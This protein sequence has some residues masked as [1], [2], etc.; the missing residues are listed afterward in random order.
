MIKSLKQRSI[1]CGPPPSYPPPIPP[2]NLSLDEKIIKKSSNLHSS[3]ISNPPSISPY[4][5]M[6]VKNTLL[7]KNIILPSNFG[8]PP[9][10]S[11]PY[12]GLINGLSYSFR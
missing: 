8:P 3:F 10:L 9:G 12:P 6:I 11:Y 2:S 4:F 5:Y 7:N 1:K